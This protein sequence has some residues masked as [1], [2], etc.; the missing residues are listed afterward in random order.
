M[1]AVAGVYMREC[2]HACMCGMSHAVV[3]AAQWS[4]RRSRC[5]GPLVCCCFCTIPVSLL[6]SAL[7]KSTLTIAGRRS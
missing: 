5:A 2:T 3:I 1:Q 7:Q 6:R 4:A